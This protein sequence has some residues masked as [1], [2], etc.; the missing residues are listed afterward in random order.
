[1]LIRHIRIW[2]GQ[3]HHNILIELIV[4]A[5][6]TI[7]L[8]LPSWFLAVH[9]GNLIAA[10]QWM[11]R[12]L[13]LVQQMYADPNQVVQAGT[14]FYLPTG[15][16]NYALMVGREQECIPLFELMGLDWHTADSLADTVAAAAPA[17]MRKRGDTYVACLQ[18]ASAP[19]FACASGG[20]DV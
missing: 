17:V 12:G 13:T 16:V 7:A 5:D 19:F 2:L 20:A 18:V 3:V 9:Y 10:N 4:G 8:C 1:M 6:V 15:Y 11:T 14:T